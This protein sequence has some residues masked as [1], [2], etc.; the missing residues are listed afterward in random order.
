MKRGFLLMNTGSPDEPTEAALRVYLKEFLMDPYVIDMPFPLRYALVHWAILPK[1][2]AESAKAYKAIWSEKGSP[3]VHYCRQLVQGLE[4]RIDDPIEMVMAYGNPSVPDGVEKLLKQGVDEICLLPL[5]PHY[6]M[7]TTG[8]CT[9]L[10]KKKIKGRATLR[11]VPP[12]YLE[13]TLIQPLAASLAGVDEHLLF[14]Y[15]GL[16]ERHIKKTDPTGSHCLNAPD[17]CE[18]E[19]P[20][21]ATCYRHQCF[22]T[23]KAVTQAA[24][25]PADRYSLSFQSRLGRDK[26]LEPSTEATLR[27]LPTLGKKNLAVICP[28]FFCDC[29]E[30][31]EEIEMRGREIFMEAGGES[32][33][34]I[35]C[36][37]DSPAAFQCLEMLMTGAD[38]WPLA[39]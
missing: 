22:E 14:S 27:K 7:A 26:W 35:P 19:S 39:R 28:A 25:I 31:L 8:G 17:C 16:P 4:K 32:F 24:G 6:A 1:R 23:T 30:T 33:R 18:K 12:F 3:L 10:V 38:D 13:P 2:P 9:A 29:L 37:N 11:V 20:A 5:F 34:M 15:H 21:H 36:L